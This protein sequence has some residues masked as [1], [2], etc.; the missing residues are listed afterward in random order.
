MAYWGAAGVS[1]AAGSVNRRILLTRLPEGRLSNE[2]FSYDTV[3][4]PAPGVGEVLCRTLY[5]SIDPA[6]RAWMQGR[7]YRAQL[8]ADDVMPANTL[9]EVVAGDLAPGTVVLTQ[10]GWQDYALVPVSAVDVVKPTILKEYLGALGITGMAAYFGL[11]R[12]AQVAATD[13]VVIS[14]AAGATGHLAGQLAAIHGCRVVGIAG[15]DSKNRWL[16]EELHFDGAVDYHEPDWR[17]TLQRLCP[18]GIDVY[19]DNVGGSVLEAILPLM[20]LHGRIACCGAVANYDTSSP[21]TRVAGIP[22]RLVN[23]RLRM[24]GVLARDFKDTWPAARTE[25]AEWLR[26]GAL[27]SV[28]EVIDGLERTPEALVGLLNGANVGKRLVRVAT[29]RQDGSALN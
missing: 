9:C 19:F 24:E 2:D 25:I 28:V 21:D 17:K 6:N 5:I 23:S 29:V 14:A 8:A 4:T 11:H 18:S 15:S 10:T 20:N 27:R 7:T 3:P 12:V 16:T 13:T 26:T 22:G 1:E